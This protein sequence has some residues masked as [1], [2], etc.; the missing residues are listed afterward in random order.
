MSK[1]DPKPARPPTLQDVATR[2]GVSRALV[3][4]VIRGVPGASEATRKR[5]LGVAEELGYRP[6]GRARLLAAGR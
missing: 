2:A 3:S 5:V 4:I 1:P 6:D